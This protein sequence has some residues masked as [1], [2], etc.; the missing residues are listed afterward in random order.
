MLT[1]INRVLCV[2]TVLSIEFNV[3]RKKTKA[4]ISLHRA[5]SLVTESTLDM[6]TFK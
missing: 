6:L 1:T 2:K 5:H 3:V 4:S